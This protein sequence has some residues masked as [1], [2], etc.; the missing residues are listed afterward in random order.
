MA[1]AQVIMM[2][3]IRAQRRVRRNPVEDFNIK[4]K[5]HDITPF[6]IHPVLP[7]ETMDELALMAKCVSDPVKNPLIGW[8]QEFYIYYIPLPGLTGWD[9]NGVLQSMMLDT[10]TSTAALQAAANSVPYYTFKGGMDYVKACYDRVVLHHFRDEDET[11][12]PILDQY[13]CAQINQERWI[14]S[15]KK[16]SAGADDLELPGIDELE[17]MDLIPGSATQ[18]AQWEMMRDHGM[19]DLTYEDY[20][21]SYGVSIADDA[22]TNA[23]DAQ[24]AKKFD[25]ELIRFVRKFT[26]PTNTVEPT[27]GVPSSAAYWSI[28]EKAT[29]KRF[30]KFPGF[31][32]GVTVTRPKIYLGSQKGHAVGLLKDAYAWL[33]ATLQNGHEYMGVQETLDTLTDGIL[34]NQTEDYWIDIQDVFRYGGQFVNHAFTAADNHGLALPT[35]AMDKKYPTEAMIDSLFTTVGKEFIRQDG[36][37]MLDI[38]T[39]S[40]RKDMTQ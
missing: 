8:W 33:P 36:T 22:V 3:D 24:K 38:L 14:N 35:A 34:Q 7:G 6:L 39:R 21:K 28:A 13:A 19:T 11:T 20:I 37:V 27:T 10:T 4:T 9:T 26:Y 31:I 32:F 25:P 15:L 2:D 23:G 16:E 12:A 1:K 18:Y 5:P 17:E 30:F 40:I 29:K